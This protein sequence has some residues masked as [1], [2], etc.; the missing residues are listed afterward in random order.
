M[1]AKSIAS[2]YEN[3]K[4]TNDQDTS[5]IVCDLF[6][7]SLSIS[8]AS[9]PNEDTKSEDAVGLQTPIKTK[10]GQV[11]DSSILKDPPPIHEPGYYDHYLF[12]RTFSIGS[13]NGELGIYHEYNHPFILIY[14]DSISPVNGWRPEF[15]TSEELE[16][17]G[18]FSLFLSIEKLINQ[19][20]DASSIAT[21]TRCVYAPEDQINKHPPSVLFISPGTIKVTSTTLFAES[22]WFVACYNGIPGIAFKEYPRDVLSVWCHA[23]SLKQAQ[24]VV[25]SPGKCVFAPVVMLL[26]GFAH[27]YEVLVDDVLLYQKESATTCFTHDEQSSPACIENLK[28][29]P[30]CGVVVTPLILKMKVSGANHYKRNLGRCFCENRGKRHCSAG[31]ISSSAA[32]KKRKSH[33][34][35]KRLRK[36]PYSS[37]AGIAGLVTPST[38]VKK[39]E[40]NHHQ[41]NRKNVTPYTSVLKGSDLPYGVPDTHSFVTP[42]SVLKKATAVF[43]NNKGRVDLLHHGLN[44]NVNIK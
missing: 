20:R 26:M 40:N 30:G 18:P 44:E 27:V 7:S 24:Q 9:S 28:K 15:L 23:E 25:S 16:K 17:I 42:S 43:P 37:G 22:D 31:A 2:V 5:S 29:S 36:K 4:N 14:R 11:F 35:D 13:Y 21:S 19:D 34:G 32:N 38:V 41:G 1:L 10:C 8:N 3:T 39:A 12:L 6:S 33:K